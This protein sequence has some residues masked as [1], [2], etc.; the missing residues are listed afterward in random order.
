[1]LYEALRGP[2]LIWA[3]I[4]A[5]HL[6]FQGSDL[7]AKFTQPDRNMLLVLWIVSLTL[8]CMRIVGD[9]VRY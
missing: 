6:A 2:T 4:L 3:L 1:M 8:M 9:L 7:P 5:V